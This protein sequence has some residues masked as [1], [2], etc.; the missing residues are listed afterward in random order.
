M[1]K[2]RRASA[3]AI[4]KKSYRHNEN[5]ET[6]FELIYSCILIGG[7]ILAL[8]FALGAFDN[9]YNPETDVCL[10]CSHKFEGAGYLNY[11]GDCSEVQDANYYRCDSWRPKTICEL[12]PNDEDC[13]CDEIKCIYQNEKDYHMATLQPF[14][15]FQ[16]CPEEAG[17]VCK[18]S[19]EGKEICYMNKLKGHNCIKS[20]P[21]SKPIKIDLEKEKCVE[22]ITEGRTGLPSNE[23]IDDRFPCGDVYQWFIERDNK[24][25]YAEGLDKYCCLAKESLNE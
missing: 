22:W 3:E 20:H 18:V 9:E 23:L 8:L 15:D 21:P 2:K 6:L 14:K 7:G 10:E 1:A 5:K 25:Y 16:D 17:G 4:R 11:Q 13:I 19:K 12:N 24:E